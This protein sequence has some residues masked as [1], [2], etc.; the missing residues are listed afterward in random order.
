[1]PAFLFLLIVLLPLVDSQDVIRFPDVSS[2]CNKTFDD[3]NTVSA[4]TT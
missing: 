3:A 4:S 1:M 2:K